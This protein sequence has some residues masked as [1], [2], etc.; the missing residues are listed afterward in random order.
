LFNVGIRNGS[1]GWTDPVGMPGLNAR[2]G[3]SRD[4]QGTPLLMESSGG[5]VRRGPTG[6]NQQKTSA[7]WAEVW[8][9]WYGISLVTVNGQV[10][11]L[12]FDP[13]QLVILGHAVGAAQ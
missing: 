5:I 6:L 2:R 4:R 8:K 3:P 7:V 10:A 12:F 9:V 13:K 1:T 11:Q